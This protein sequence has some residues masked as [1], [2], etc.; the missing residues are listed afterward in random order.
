MRKSS[1]LVG[2]TF[3]A[4]AVATAQPA[5]AQDTSASNPECVDL[6]ND[7][8]CDDNRTAAEKAEGM[9]LVTGSRTRRPDAFSSIEPLTVITADEITQSGFNSATD[10]LQG[11]AVTAGAGQINNF[12]SGFV[13]AGGTGANTLGLRNLGP[14]RTL[15]LLNGRRLSPAGTRGNLVAADLNVLPTA[16]VERIEILKAGASSI[17]GSDAVA[18]VVNIITDA[19][20][21]GLTIDAQVNIPE[22]GAG[23]DRRISATFG[24]G[25]DRLNVIG[26]LE[27]RKRDV[28][29]LNDVDF[30]DCPVGGFL[31]GEG[32][33]FGSG[34]GVGFD[35]TSCFTL[36]NGGVT[37][38]T[39]GLPTRDG[40]GRTSG[41]AGRFNRFVPSAAGTGGATPGFLGVGFYDRDTFDPASQEE[42]LVTPVEIYTGFLSAT[43]D[44]NI[45]GNAEFYAEV[46]ATRRKSSATLYRQLS[47][48]YLRGSPL[49]PALYR[50]GVFANP[51]NTSSGQ[52]I[53]ARAFIGFGNTESR[54]EVD[55]VRAGGG[56]RGDFVAPGWRYDLYV[57]K[58]WADGT[59]EIESFLVDRLATS[60][61][62]VQ[63]ANGTFSCAAQAAIANCVAAPELNA[64]TIGGRLPSAFRD[65]ILDNTIGTTLFRETTF[66]I[67]FDGPL[68]TLPGGEVQLAVGA[69]YRKQRIDDTPDDNSIRGNLF[70]LTAAVP[71]R[72]TDSVKEVFGELFVPLI[73]DR[74][75][76]ENVSLNGSVRYTDYDSYGSDVTYKISGEWEFFD[77]VGVRGSYGT[78]YRAPALAEQFLGTTSGF[79]GSGLDPCD[80]DGFPADPD[81]AGPLPRPTLSANQQLRVTNCAAIGLD[82][83][84][85]QQN[86]GIT[87]FTR[88]G[89]ETG[90][91]AETST[92]WSVGV[93]LQPKISQ[94]VS[95]SFAVDYFDIK[96]ENGVSTL[97]GGTILNRCYSAVDFDPSAGFCRF[98]QR[99]P[100]NALTVTSGFV[101][102]STDIVKGYEF[103]GRVSADV[104]DGRLTFNANV[105][106]YTE[107]SDKLFPEEFL[108]DANGTLNNPDW[109]G[110]FDATYRR[111]PIFL[112]YGIEWFDSSSGTYA[113]NATSRQTGLVNAA[114]EQQLRD[115]FIL[116]VPDYFLHSASV[117]FTISEKFEATIGV[118]NLFNTEPPRISAGVTTIGNA[119]LYSGYDYT[120][121]QF[122]MN[123]TFD[124]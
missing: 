40:I 75:F 59:A 44:T 77:G 25:D 46:L 97:A 30:T 43:Y 35:G 117:Q 120:G 47:L 69:E 85:F 101:N 14:A 21:R 106:R 1:L 7:G 92:N 13:T 88:G 73:S 38:N 8:T 94:S 84:T 51:T 52:Q 54:Q 124:F 71:T 41:A 12:F 33:E 49:V 55:Y 91:A 105:T 78:S 29:K 83:L 27:Y 95:V 107:Q 66:A 89:A 74:P 23:L 104:L 81:G 82:A 99:D 2:T 42:E 60:L 122:F 67:G 6:N 90:L 86:S 57:G 5:L 93:V 103:T 39:V 16:I 109:V 3:L 111:G 62:V 115:D 50:N 112:R 64:D 116:E 118:R 65:Y 36:D 53:A 56:L 34:D 121:R 72:G 24:F 63:N 58:S 61:N 20:I 113:F 68:F 100:N 123:V 17:Y 48:D 15:T 4:V 18:G 102:L 19:R 31:T 87:S 26:S 96:V 70:G 28:I 22:I 110:T 119:P 76:M 45:L 32:T 108:L 80:A 98:V 114:T 37:I 79:L 10:A 9:I 11:L